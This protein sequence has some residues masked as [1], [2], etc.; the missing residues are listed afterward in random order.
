M[1]I[2]R[3]WRPAGAPPILRR[4]RRAA[5]P[6]RAGARMEIDLANHSAPKKSARQD[7]L[8]RARNRTVRTRVRTLVRALRSAIEANDRDAITASFQEA[9]R[10]IRK[11]ASK[12]VLPKRQADRKVSRLARAA[13]GAT[14]S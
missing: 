10:A 7:L 2:W 14:P 5:C 3:N 4:P 8:R 9:E 13:N 11:A 1:R 12:G 6:K